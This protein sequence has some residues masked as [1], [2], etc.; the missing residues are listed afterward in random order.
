MDIIGW[1]PAGFLSIFTEGST[2]LI[3]FRDDDNGPFRERQLH[4]VFPFM[5]LQRHHLIAL[6]GR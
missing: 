5:R 4:L 2:V 3:F 1:E 6:V